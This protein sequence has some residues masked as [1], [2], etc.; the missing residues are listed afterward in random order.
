[1]KFHN[2]RAEY[3][4]FISIIDLWNNAKN[5]Y[6]IKKRIRPV[7]IPI[8]NDPARFLRPRISADCFRE[9][10]LIRTK[11]IAGINIQTNP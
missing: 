1:V 3:I 10:L 7:T 5:T 6:T 8:G 4:R 11:S 9:F 2:D